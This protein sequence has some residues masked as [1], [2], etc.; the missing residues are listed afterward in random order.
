MIAWL[1]VST[2]LELLDLTWRDVNLA[3][4]AAVIT[5]RGETAKDADVRLIPVSIRLAGFL[6]MAETDP[7]GQEYGSEKFVFGEL[8]GGK[9][10]SACRAELRR[11]NLHF[12]DMRRE[13]GSRW[14]EGGFQL[15]EVRDLL[16]HANVSQTDTYLSTR[17]TGLR[18]AMKRF[19]AARG[20]LVA[21]PESMAQRPL[22]HDETEESTKDQLH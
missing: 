8:T 3:K 17:I 4:G 19:D 13:G 5:V 7:S 14:H 11:I 10:S 22:S 1:S 2:A 15:H 6:E 18:E 16:G 21:K 12:H 20:N 9:L